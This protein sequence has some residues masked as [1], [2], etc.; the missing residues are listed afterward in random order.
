MYRK[1][2]LCQSCIGQPFYRCGDVLVMVVGYNE[3][4][5]VLPILL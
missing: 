3:N 4:E 2:I 5:E 1:K